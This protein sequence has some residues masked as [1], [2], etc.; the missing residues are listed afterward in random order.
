M[1]ILFLLGLAYSQSLTFNYDSRMS[2]RRKK[3]HNELSKKLS[4]HITNHAV[5]FSTLSESIYGIQNWKSDV[6][7]ANPQFDQFNDFFIL[8]SYFLEQNRRVYLFL[9]P[10]WKDNAVVIASRYHVRFITDLDNQ[11][12][13]QMKKFFLYEIFL[14]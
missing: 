7:F 1:I 3:Y 14:K 5:L 6:I 2:T 10:E 13:F 12:I 11:E 4:H 8:A 9:T